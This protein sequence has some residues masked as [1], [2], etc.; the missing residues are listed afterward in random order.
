MVQYGLDIIEIST[1]CAVRVCFM[2]WLRVYYGIDLSLSK[3]SMAQSSEMFR[4]Q[5]KSKLKKCCIFK[6]KS[7]FFQS[8]IARIIMIMIRDQKSV[9]LQSIASVDRSKS[10]TEY[11]KFL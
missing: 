11:V 2:G 3:L 8:S 4:E 6:N 5:H 1:G 10:F 9:K 7:I